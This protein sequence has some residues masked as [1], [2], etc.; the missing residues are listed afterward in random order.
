MGTEMDPLNAVLLRWGVGSEAGGA[1]R[2]K[3]PGAAPS[4]K[5]ILAG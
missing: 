2:L 1:W 3:G 4:P 5:N